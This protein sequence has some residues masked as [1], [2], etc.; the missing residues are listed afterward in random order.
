MATSKSESERRA[1]NEEAK[2]SRDSSDIMADLRS[3]FRKV[4]TPSLCF[5][6][7]NSASTSAEAPAS[8]SEV[9][10]GGSN[11]PSISRAV[12]ENVNGCTQITF[13]ALMRPKSSLAA[14]ENWA[15]AQTAARKKT[16]LV[17]SP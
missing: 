1:R 9:T 17:M 8:E 15:K 5:R 12:D 7:L 3:S 16:S 4:F 6:V 11:A 14:E 2:I 10:E 13:G